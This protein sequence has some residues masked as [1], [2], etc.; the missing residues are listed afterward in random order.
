VTTRGRCA[1]A[2]DAT[3]QSVA[4]AWRSLRRRPGLIIAVS[5]T[6]GLG[7]GANAAMFQVIDRLL[8]QPPPYLRDPA[9]VNRVYLTW[10]VASGRDRLGP[11][12]E[13][14]RI[15]DLSRWTT[16]FSQTAAFS[17]QQL[18][19]GT[20]LETRE[21]TVA[22]VSASLFS[23]FDAAPAVGRYFTAEEDTPPAGT[24]LAV[25][26]YAFWRSQY[27]GRSD[28]IGRGLQIGHE[29]YTIVGVAPRNF[30]GMSDAYV[31]PQSADAESPSVF[32]PLT[33]YAATAGVVDCRYA[34]SYCWVWL[35]MFVRRRPGVTSQ[36]ASSNL[37]Q[38]F[39]WSYV[40]S[41]SEA[42]ARD[43]IEW[44]TR[45]P[46]IELARPR[47]IAAPVLAARGPM[48]SATA[49]VA[50]WVT[51]VA[52][53]V[54][55]I[56]CA[57][58]T[59]LLLARS[60]E[61]RAEIALRLALG[62]SQ[63]RLAGQLLIECLLLALMS[64]GVAVVVAGLGGTVLTSMFIPG[65]DSSVM[66]QPRTL[67]F[68][69]T[70]T[71]LAGM[72]IGIGPALHAR[73]I[74]VIDA[75]K[76]GHRGRSSDRAQT[77]RLLLLLQSGLSALLLIGAGL[78]TRSIER[79]GALRLGYDVRPVLHADVELRQTKLDSVARHSLALRMVDAAKA[80]PGVTDA[81]RASGV[82]FIETE[83]AELFVP[84]IAT[85][86]ALGRF[87]DQSVSPE[88]FGTVGTRIVEGRGFTNA[89]GARA[90]RVAVISQ[91]MAQA[92]WPG[93]DPIGKRIRVYSDTAPY[94]TVVGVAENTRQTSLANDH[95]LNYYLPIDQDDDGVSTELYIRTR[96][97]AHAYQA[98]VRRVLQLL[99]PGD[100]YVNLTPMQAITDPELRSWHVG[101]ELF[102]AF[103]GLA[104][105]VAA[106][107]LYSV[108]SYDVARRRH[109]LGVRVA[110]GARP[111]DVFR[112]L[113]TDST[114]FVVIGAGIGSAIAFVSG[115]S[116]APLLFAESP[117]D[118]VVFG[119][120]AIALAA[121]AFAATMIPVHS[122]WRV[123]PNTAL[124]AE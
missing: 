78:F 38:A 92:L 101:A 112:L 14:L 84:G 64:G 19:V 5:L 110:L 4:Y 29:R 54:L 91:A 31:D 121:A 21:L 3:T 122:A 115:S 76:G 17:T 2:I 96:G 32:V 37:T 63:Q 35:Q 28:V 8:L 83:S 74:S 1:A 53:M 42:A 72:V 39:Q 41:R 60:R 102:V 77:R 47:A 86:A 113:M 9:A 124:R 71:L 105:I 82:P 51:G 99:A 93:Q 66:N 52:G 40:A 106:V 85:V 111:R 103:G 7:L 25:L 50:T 61:R 16:A 27:E 81:A 107:G 30:V 75:L 58:V 118:P 46:T 11:F 68:G 100:A 55:L 22:A 117:R 33:T 62:I 45:F 95:E 18:P 119:V 59:N 24:A 10:H 13:Y 108:I 43:Y 97:D 87:Y 123:D 44:S 65:A 67:L 116:I 79:A 57:N 120:V 56:A 34:T 23:F 15:R 89:D 80:I 114:R 20:G 49:R 36:V 26:S 109:E 70:A 98:T 12:M 6:L 69:A 73:R 88:Y 48:E 94:T 90:P 104:L